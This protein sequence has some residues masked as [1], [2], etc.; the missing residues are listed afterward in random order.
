MLHSRILNNK[1]NR[2]HERAL[3]T[4]YSD[5]KS[6]FNKLVDKYSSFTIHQKNVQS[7]A[8]KSFKFL[9]FKVDITCLC[10]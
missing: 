8:I 5:Y 2:L 10:S 9:I 3:R 1:I 7:L 6:S 4:V